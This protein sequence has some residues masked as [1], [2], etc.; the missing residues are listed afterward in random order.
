[1]CAFG[2]ARTSSS[3][4][5]AARAR[6]LFRGACLD[7][8]AQGEGLEAI[9]EL[10]LDGEAVGEDAWK[11]IGRRGFDSPKYFRSYVRAL[12]WNC[13]AATNPRPFQAR[14]AP[15]QD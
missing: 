4:S 14:F 5:R 10:E 3:T 1:L 13:V 15:V 11:S 7:D 2:R 9:W 12:R 8:D 6:I